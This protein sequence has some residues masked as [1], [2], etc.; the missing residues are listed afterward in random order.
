MYGIML[1]IR[2][3]EFTIIVFRNSVI[4]ILITNKVTLINI[5]FTI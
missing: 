2:M 5:I 1:S 3:L 4:I